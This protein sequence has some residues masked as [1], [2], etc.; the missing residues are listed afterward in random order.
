MKDLL[1]I[2]ESN[3]E[4]VFAYEGEDTYLALIKDT[5]L[6]EY[7]NYL[8]KLS[9]TGY[10][11]HTENEIR[12]NRFA[13][14]YC[15][16]YVINAGFYPYSSESRLTIEK[17]RKLLGLES[18]NVWVKNDEIITSFAHVGLGEHN[19]AGLS[20]VLQLADGSFIIVDGGYENCAEPL[21]NYLKEKSPTENITVAA[22]I[23]THAD[24]D[25]CRAF[26]R[27]MKSY[28]ADTTVEVLISSFLTTSNRNEV[29]VFTAASENGVDMVKAHTGY[30][31]YAR[32]SV[33]EFLYTIDN[34][35][36]GD[37]GANASSLC[38]AIETEGE[39]ILITGDITEGV[40]T[41]MNPMYGDYLKSDILQL[42]HHGLRNGTGRK[43]DNTREFYSLVRPEVIFW[44]VFSKFFINSIGA[45]W[46]NDPEFG[47]VAAIA[48][49]YWNREAEKYARE[50]YLGGDPITVLELP[51]RRY[52]AYN[53]VSGQKREP[54][55]LDIAYGSDDRL[56]FEKECTDTSIDRISWND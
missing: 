42:S 3:S 19:Q 22:W 41:V 16:E 44:P 15:D 47:N 33:V 28:A 27:Y 24:T 13:T 14:Y 31:L 9:A 54:V 5:S 39:R 51:Y 10:T 29:D 37:I 25:H 7:E 56:H 53:F 50:V 46:I 20:C 1:P 55:R 21:H 2:Y 12:G 18:D 23:L 49:F 48:E 34:L 52:S 30:K 35:L 6:E 26:V 40:T 8:N 4:P 11:K 36:P 45:D 32:N 17:K 38:F 43:M